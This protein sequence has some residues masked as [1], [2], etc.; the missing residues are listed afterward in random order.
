MVQHGDHS[1]PMIILQFEETGTEGSVLDQDQEAQ[2]EDSK[3]LLSIKKIFSIFLVKDCVF[4][5]SSKFLTSSDDKIKKRLGSGFSKAL[6][7]IRVQQSL[8]PDPGSAKP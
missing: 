6:I 5:L 4:Y 7:R 3:V 8:D 2:I 1:G